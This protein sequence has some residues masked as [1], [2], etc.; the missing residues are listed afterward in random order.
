[1]IDDP[2][3]FSLPVN[4]LRYA[5]SGYDPDNDLCITAIWTLSDVRDQ[6]RHCDDFGPSFPYV[7]IS[8]G[9]GV[10]CWELSSDVTLHFVRGCIDFEDFNEPIDWA[11]DGEEH[12]DEVD[13]TLF[14]ESDAWSGTV[15]FDNTP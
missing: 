12:S 14:V 13:L 1:V 10:G 15:H 11:G 8:P 2:V 9:E 4:S 3:F 7:T 6:V 5:V